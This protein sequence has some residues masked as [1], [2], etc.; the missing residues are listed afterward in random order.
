M[1]APVFPT[2]DLPGSTMMVKVEFFGRASL[3][4][5]MVGVA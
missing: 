4:S 1:S 5:A 3:R 2:S